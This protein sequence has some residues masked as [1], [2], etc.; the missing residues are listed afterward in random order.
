MNIIDKGIRRILSDG[1]WKDGDD[2]TSGHCITTSLAYDCNSND[3]SAA[4]DAIKA[5]LGV[6]RLEDVWAFNDAPETSREDALLLMKRAS[7]RL[8]EQS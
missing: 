1:W 7:E 6:E 4:W 2:T 5:E 3:Q 8:D